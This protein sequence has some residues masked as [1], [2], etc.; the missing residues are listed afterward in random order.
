ML[1]QLANLQIDLIILDLMLPGEDG[2]KLCRDLRSG[3]YASIRDPD[4]DPRAVTK[5]IVSWG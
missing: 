4:A 2:L 1:H 5:P 3:D